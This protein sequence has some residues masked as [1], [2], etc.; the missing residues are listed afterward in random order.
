MIGQACQKRSRSKDSLRRGKRDA[1]VKREREG[2]HRNE[3]ETESK[4]VL[5]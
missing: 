2:G 4:D 1:A 3:R 5:H